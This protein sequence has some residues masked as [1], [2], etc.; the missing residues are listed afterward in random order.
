MPKNCTNYH[1]PVNILLED[2]SRLFEHFSDTAE[3]KRDFLSGTLSKKLQLISTD[4]KISDS[5]ECIRHFDE[6]NNEY[7]QITV[8]DNYCQYLWSLCYAVL[9]VMDE[10]LVKPIMAPKEKCDQKKLNE[11]YEVFMTAMALYDPKRGMPHPRVF[12]ELPNP[13]SHETDKNVKAANILF[14]T[15]LCFILFHEYQHY[16]LG[17][18]EQDGNKSDEYAADYTAFYQMYEESTPK[19]KKYVPY[20][21]IMTLGSLFFAD[22][23]MEGGTHPDPDCRLKSLILCMDN[24]DP[25][26]KEY[27]YG[28]GITLYRLWAFYYSHENVIP[29]IEP[30]TSVEDYFERVQQAVISFKSSQTVRI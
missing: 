8:W 30:D 13:V 3:L 15:C 21:I 17:H 10:C 2:A 25:R 19:E 20:G 1:F 14:V 4:E 12:Y 23:T 28:M 27:C 5:A 29:E 26:S 22:D 7:Y 24:L 9:V 16:K 6:E 18:M 11:S